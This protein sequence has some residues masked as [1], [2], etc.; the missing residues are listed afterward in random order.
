[1]VISRHI[2]DISL[3]S[4][5]CTS[6][7]CLRVPVHYVGLD[8]V[9]RSPC[10]RHPHHRLYSIQHV[11]ILRSERALLWKDADRGGGFRR[12]QL[13]GG[14]RHCCTRQACCWPSWRG[15]S[16]CQ[17]E[18]RSGVWPLRRGRPCPAPPRRDRVKGRCQRFAAAAPGS[19]A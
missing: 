8:K 13:G 1:M 11:A 9:R 10:C 12:L 2:S 3:S 7:N 5:P 19:F 18:S 4:S 15:A 17:T 16:P 14:R 6:R